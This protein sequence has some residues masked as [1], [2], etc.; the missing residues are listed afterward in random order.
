MLPRATY[1]YIQSWGMAPTRLVL[2][3]CALSSWIFRMT[4][5]SR[6]FRTNI[7]SARPSS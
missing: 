3:S 1:G 6:I 7:C 2:R 5:T 4:R